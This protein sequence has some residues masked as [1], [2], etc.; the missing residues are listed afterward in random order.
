MSTITLPAANA[1]IN[2]CGD[3]E[4]TYKI[5]YFDGATDITSKL[6]GTKTF[7]ISSPAT[8]LPVAVKTNWAFAGWKNAAENT[9]TTVTVDSA[10]YADIILYASFD[11]ESETGSD[12]KIYK[13]IYS[14]E[15]LE[16]FADKVNSGERTLNAKLYN[17]TITYPKLSIR[18]IG[19]TVAYSKTTANA[20]SF[21]VYSNNERTSSYLCTLSNYT[22]LT[23]EYIAEQMNTNA[24]AFERLYSDEIDAANYYVDHLGITWGTY[25]WTKS[26]KNYAGTFDGNG[27]VISSV[28]YGGTIS[29]Q[30]SSFGLFATTLSGAS[31]KNLTLSGGSLTLTSEQLSMN[32]C[33]SPFVSDS[34]GNI[35]FYNCNNSVPINIS[36]VST[37]SYSFIGGLIGRLSNG[38]VTIK[39][40]SS[41]GAINS[42][43][44]YGYISGLLGYSLSG[45]NII[46]NSYV[47]ANI[48]SSTATATYVSGIA[49]TAGTVRNCYYYGTI[50]ATGSSDTDVSPIITSEVTTSVSNCYY[51][52]TCGF[53]SSYGTAKTATEFSSGEVA[54]LL[55]GTQ[56]EKAWG[57]TSFSASSVPI[58]SDTETT[59]V[60]KIVCTDG[61][62]YYN[63]GV[64][65][66]DATGDFYINAADYT[67]IKNS[68]LGADGGATNETA[69]DINGDGVID[70]LDVFMLEGVLS[71][72]KTPSN[73]NS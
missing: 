31:I 18:L 11:L 7:S 42:G 36:G 56:Y 6:T 55:Q 61:T 53:S 66:C 57:Q 26:L 25:T 9:F 45:T 17:Q 23:P 21:G 43:E 39:S 40:C 1:T 37:T 32:V 50:T 62:V 5:R 70:V 19:G 54:F 33:A 52:N 34:Y 67:A 58:I 35:T 13:N 16:I 59:R 41:T 4:I 73:V 20:S 46:E 38:S 8:D 65:L 60:R 64:T 63:T 44:R 28:T 51:L 27:T 72:H 29:P 15:Q 68:A 2:L 48:T 14:L 3:K 49:S 69:A 22:G 47:K 71:G 10:N 12:G 30:K 24:T